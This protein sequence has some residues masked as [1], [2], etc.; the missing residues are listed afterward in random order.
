MYDD[1][2]DYVILESQTVYGR[3]STEISEVDYY[4]LD[5]EEFKFE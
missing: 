4:I 1:D 3:Q 5:S 2:V